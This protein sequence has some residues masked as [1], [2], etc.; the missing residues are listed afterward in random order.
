MSVGHLQSLWKLPSYIFVWCTNDAG[1]EVSMAQYKHNVNSNIR[2]DSLNHWVFGLRLGEA[3]VHY[4]ESYVTVKLKQDL[5][6]LLLSGTL[7]TI[8]GDLVVWLFKSHTI[9]HASLL[10]HMMMRETIINDT[11]FVKFYFYSAL[12]SIQSYMYISSHISSLVNKFTDIIILYLVDKV[13]TIAIRNS[14]WKKYIN[15]CQNYS[16]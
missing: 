6:L 9:I 5:L 12:F 11:L 15:K 4:Y 14:D 7:M 13:L 8:E 2:Q 3:S 16:I 10:I 1:L